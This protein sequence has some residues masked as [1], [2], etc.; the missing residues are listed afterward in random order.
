MDVGADSARH[1][2]TRVFTQGYASPEQRAG[3]NVSTAT[4]VYALGVVLREMLSGERGSAQ[5]AELPEGFMALP[6]PADLR[7]ILAR[8]TEAEPAHR[9]PTVEAL[10]AD[11]ARWREGR[12]VLAAPDSWH[13]RTRKFIGRHRAGVVLVLL[14]L[15]A[16]SGLVW[17]LAVERSRA[18]AAEKQTA[19]ALAVAERETQAARASL[20]FLSR[21]LAAA[22]PDVAMSTQIS[23]R[24]LLDQAR[25][26]IEA[27]ASLPTP[28]RRS[29]QR[30]LG[31]LY[32]SLGE[33]AIAATLLAA[34]SQ[35]VIPE[36]R[37][38]ALAFATA[39][40]GD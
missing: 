13:Y 6:L 10:R 40:T 24:D 23:V 9:Y 25:A 29:V 7:G 27:D 11:L 33:P 31:T 35:D 4:D 19:R 3:Q 20:D 12:P 22:S 26:G 36:S 37:S 32:M 34:G 17:R 18:L 16:S 15:L 39:R 5:P 30:L 38:E 14:A 21:T 2:S 1:T 28:A 8:A